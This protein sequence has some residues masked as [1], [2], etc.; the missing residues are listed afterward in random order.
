MRRGVQ[1][2]L[3]VLVA[4]VFFGTPRAAGQDEVSIQFSAYLLP[5]KS[6]GP[7]GRTLAVTSE[8]HYALGE[9]AVPVYLKEGRQS[10]EYPYRGPRTLN[11][12]RLTTK[13][14]ESVRVPV[15][16]TTIPS[17]A[18]KG[19]LILDGSEGRLQVR[20]LWLGASRLGRGKA[21]IYNLAGRDLGLVF[22]GKERRS[23]KT[24]KST[25]LKGKFGTGD[26]YGFTK[27]EVY[28]M[29]KRET[30]VTPMKV[31]NRNLAI[32]REDT[33]IFILVPKQGE[34]LSLLTLNA[35]GAD[36]PARVA[37][38]KKYLPKEKPPAE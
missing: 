31:F 7:E 20:P 25:E 13:D 1:G 9:S 21:I 11:L 33:A 26:E 22:G 27:L 37:E 28:V 10:I 17:G 16:S 34:F 36:D 19:L 4:A 8:L 15:V 6:A 24:G 30:K 29:K 3:A 2:V 14:G 23:L 5:G 18:K 35:G 32:P 38:L 12:F